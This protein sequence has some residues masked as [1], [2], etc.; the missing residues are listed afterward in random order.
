MA[1]KG[2]V[3]LIDPL[4]KTSSTNAVPPLNIVVGKLFFIS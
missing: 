4:I 2:L 1:N 3:A